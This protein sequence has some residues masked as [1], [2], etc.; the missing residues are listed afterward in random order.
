[1]KI[2]KNDYSGI[3]K[4]LTES[5]NLLAEAEDRGWLHHKITVDDNIIYDS[6]SPCKLILRSKNKNILERQE[7]KDEPVV[8]NK[9]GDREFPQEIGCLGQYY[10]W[11]IKHPITGVIKDCF[12]E[13]GN[14]VTILE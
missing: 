7:Y 4:T 9:K 8:I 1:M 14:I 11:H 6:A 5:I 10:Q 12:V 2:I 13:D 3:T